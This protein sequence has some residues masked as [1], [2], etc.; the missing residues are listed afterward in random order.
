MIERPRRYYL[1][2]GREAQC[3]GDSGIASAWYAKQLEQPGTTLDAAFPHKAALAAQHYV[4]VEDLDGATIE[5][6]QQAGLTAA[7]AAIVLAAI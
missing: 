6:L 5:E 1:L 3:R 4:A 7:Q 2:K